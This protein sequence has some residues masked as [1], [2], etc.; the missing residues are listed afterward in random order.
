MLITNRYSISTPAP[1]LATNDANVNT[2]ITGATWGGCNP[3]TQGAT[4]NAAAGNG[5]TNI[6]TVNTFTDQVIGKIVQVQFV[7]T[8]TAGVD[9][10]NRV[11]LSQLGVTINKGVLGAAIVG[12]YD[13]NAVENN[14]TPTPSWINVGTLGLI[15]IIKDALVLKI[16]N[17][18]QA[19][20]QNK[21]ASILLIYT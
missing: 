2:G 8:L 20:F 6:T 1:V 3:S 5:L 17:G 16:P 21:T 15:S 14:N 13:T 7:G 18:N 11:P 10:Y 12:V 4:G 19:L 9:N